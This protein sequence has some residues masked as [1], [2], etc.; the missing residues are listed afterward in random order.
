MFFALVLQ[1]ISASETN[2]L[3]TGVSLTKYLKKHE[4]TILFV[5]NT[6]ESDL[7]FAS[8]AIHRYA[9]QIGFAKTSEDQV[10]SE[11][12]KDY[13][14]IIPFQRKKP[15]KTFA[16]PKEPEPF[17]NWVANVINPTFYKVV[18]SSQLNLLL[19]NPTPLLISVDNPEIQE[20]AD[21]L[22]IN[23]VTSD[24]LRQNNINLEKGYYIYRPSDNTFVPYNGSFVEESKTNLIHY[25]LIP[26]DSKK[27]VAGYLINETN[28]DYYQRLNNI[29][30]KYGNQFLFT[31]IK[32]EDSK[33]FLKNSRLT[34]VPSPY[35]FV[36]NMTDMKY[37]RY[38]LTNESQNYVE[39]IGH[40]LS[41]ITSKSVTPTVISENITETYGDKATIKNIN[42]NNFKEYVY[43]DSHDTVV[44]FTAEDCRFCKIY[45]KIFSK[46]ASFLSSTYVYI[47]MFDTSKNDIPKG[48]P[49]LES[50]PYVVMWPAGKKDQP[51]VFDSSN[52]S[53]IL[54]F[55]KTCAT[56]K[57]EEKPK[58]VKFI[59][60]K[61]SSFF[62]KAK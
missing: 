47:Y 43:D 24:L 37:E 50:Y 44:V 33:E 12:C 48:V 21:N 8:E 56:H 7:S 31:I 18:S 4:K 26:K 30:S 23:M 57:F 42:A 2:D 53:D 25:S 34:S 55:I 35:F 15:F 17:A 9:E 60:E 46:I 13:P 11:L 14:C 10:P 27:L 19:D 62:K 59:D 51:N 28:N 5:T 38:L 16:A 3:L 1:L 20:S 45:N 58:L 36:I 32:L 6:K 54:L 61:V 49:E 40:F 39:D 22:T 52:L 41:E 29:S